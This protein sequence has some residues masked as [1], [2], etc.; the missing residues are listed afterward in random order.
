[1]PNEKNYEPSEELRIPEKTR[2]EALRLAVEEKDK[3]LLWEWIAFNLGVQ[4][5]RKQICPDHN[6]PFD[7]V[8]D[9]IFNEF[10][11]AVVLANRSG[12]KTIDFAILDT[13]MSYF[14]PAEIATVGA[15][16]AQAQRCYEYFQNFSDRFPFAHHKKEKS[17]KRTTL[18]NG[19]KVEI[20][21]GTVSGV[22][23]PH[24]QLLFLDEIDLMLWFILQQAF[25]MPQSKNGI[26]SK[27]VITST[28]KFPSGVMQRAID[29]AKHDEDTKLYQWCIWEVIEKLPTDPKKLKKILDEFKGQLPDRIEEADGYYSW[30]DAITK[31]RK[32]DPEVW[33][34]E[35]LCRRP[36]LEGVIYGSVYS[37]EE[38]MIDWTPTDNKQGYI[39]LF[40]DFGNVE[41]HPNVVLFAFV[42][43]TFDRVIIFDEL[44][45]VGYDTEEIWQAIESKLATYGMSI[46]ENVRGWIPDYHG[47]TEIA[48]R[49]RRGAPMMEKHKEGARY[50]VNNGIKMVKNL[51]RTGRI[52]FTRNCHQLH[53]EMM[54]YK[55]K[56]NLDGTYSTIPIKDNDHGP[57]ALRYGIILLYDLLIAHIH[58]SMEEEKAPAEQPV[59]R[60]RIRRKTITGDLRKKE[61]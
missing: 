2:L 5:P 51:L 31:H 44:Y 57:D 56:K 36:G 25:S 40:E 16:Q 38:N 6:A 29:E 26:E 23:S 32:L 24:P 21:T 8:A 17:M 61:F 28:R 13:I 52:M 10:R 41:K 58:A 7:F 45:L 1:M 12:G 18:D 30:D 27:I 48:D 11:N 42:P 53:L 33:D 47:I 34:A 35:W 50:E 43:T 22:N 9:Y 46:A 49:R 20:V 54:G 19:A 3:D 60:T 37:E 15:I 55:R 59:Q 39:Y 4:I 14:L